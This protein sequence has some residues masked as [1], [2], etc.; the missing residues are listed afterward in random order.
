MEEGELVESPF[1]LPLRA[2]CEG[3]EGDAVLLDD[4]SIADRLSEEG[5][6]EP[7]ESYRCR[8]CRR[9]RMRLIVGSAID[10]D[11]PGRADYVVVVKC[12]ACARESR[13][14][15]SRGRP[16]EQE[17]ALDVLYGRR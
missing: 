10:P 9:G 12:R 8:V 16:S 1:W 13:I 3:C 14:A 2:R 5:R 4:D 15:W 7:L 17:V 6:R 11:A